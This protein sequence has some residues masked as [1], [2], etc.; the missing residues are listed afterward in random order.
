MSTLVT[1]RRNPREAAKEDTRRALLA[2]G[3]FEFVE[4]G[5]DSPSLDAICARAGYTRGAFYVHFKDREDFLVA[6]ME[7]VLGGF[8]DATIATD[9]AGEDLEQTI[10]RFAAA[11]EAGTVPLQAQ[12]A[13]RSHHLLEACVRSAVIRTR[14]VSMLRQ[15]IARVATAT[16]EGQRAGRIHKGVPAAEVGVLLVALAMGL[17]QMSELGLQLDVDAA[18]KATLALLRRRP[19]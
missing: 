9:A 12:G 3:V 18:R 19:R 2:A 1:E 4:H 5:L 11:L 6:V 14:F 16:R 13:I 10:S 8:L 15:V 17:S 7:W